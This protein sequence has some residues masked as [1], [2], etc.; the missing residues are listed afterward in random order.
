MNLCPKWKK[1]TQQSHKQIMPKEVSVKGDY[2]REIPFRA[3]IGEQEI[4]RE[5]SLPEDGT[6]C[7]SQVK[8]F[9]NSA[10]YVKG[11]QPIRAEDFWWV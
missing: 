2:I 8:Q 5:L 1:T 10:M 9:P 11:E 4:T 6:G 7:W 3:I